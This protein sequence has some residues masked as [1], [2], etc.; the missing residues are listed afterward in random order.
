M[1]WSTLS[2]SSL[3]VAVMAMSTAWARTSCTAW[4]SAW[5]IFSRAARSWSASDYGSRSVC[6][7]LSYRIVD[8]ELLAQAKSKKIDT[9]FYLI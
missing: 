2:V 1:A 5:A 9:L 8:H 4:V 6:D 3:A 7:A